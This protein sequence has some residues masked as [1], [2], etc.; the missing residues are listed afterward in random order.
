MGGEKVS[1]TLAT[2]QSNPVSP[3]QKRKCDPGEGKD[4]W[5][6]NSSMPG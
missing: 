6:V 3:E 2:R 4:L 1:K 5:D